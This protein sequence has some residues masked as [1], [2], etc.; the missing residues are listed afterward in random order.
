MTR[1]LTSCF[2][3]KVVEVINPAPGFH[4]N[5][6]IAQSHLLTASLDDAYHSILVYVRGLELNVRLTLPLTGTLTT[7]NLSLL[8]NLIGSEAYIHQ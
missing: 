2:H 4:Y 8:N 5:I 3:L 7:T 1:H 6:E